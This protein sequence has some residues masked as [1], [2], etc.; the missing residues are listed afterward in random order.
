MGSIAD[1]QIIP[2]YT[3]DV[4]IIPLYTVLGLDKLHDYDVQLKW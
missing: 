1:E 2:L 3:V 4:Q